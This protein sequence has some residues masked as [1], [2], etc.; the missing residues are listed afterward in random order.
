[1]K[2]I[3]YDSKYKDKFIE[4]NKDWII[5]NF[6]TLEKEDEET[7]ENIEK[8]LENGAMVYFSIENDEVLATCMS[9]PM[10]YD[11]WEICKLASNKHRDHKGSGSAVFE[12]SMNWAIEHGAKKLLLF[13]NRR[14]KP[15]IHIYEK[16][17]F[18]ELNI[19]DYGYTRGDIAFEKILE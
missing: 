3:K 13:S 14:L 8:E 6:G 1:M 9:K 19:D 17:G 11:T 15:A 10:Q 18:K 16:F 4:Y 12:A 7:F 2:I 5:D